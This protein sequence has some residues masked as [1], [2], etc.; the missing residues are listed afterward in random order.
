M[1]RRIVTI[2]LLALLFSGCIGGKSVPT[3]RY[4]ELAFKG[5]SSQVCDTAPK[6]V[7]AIV[8]PAALSFLD[9][10]E[11]LYKRAGNEAGYYAAHQWIDRP[12]VLLQKSLIEAVAQACHE[13]L[14]PPAIGVRPDYTLQSTLLALEIVETDKGA[15][16]VV[17][18]AFS[19]SGARSDL[20]RGKAEVP[21]A[22]VE[23]ESVMRAL[24]EAWNQALGTLN[25]H[26]QKSTN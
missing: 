1:R 22:S 21:L 14:L 12:A 20:W 2:A 19:L 4:Y 11:I 10:R 24:N 15:K 5:D 8:P 9:R 13:V 6:G 3:P 23:I 26:L 7:V 16:A 17:E 18:I 25:A